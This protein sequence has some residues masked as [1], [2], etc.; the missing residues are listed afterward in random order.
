MDLSES[1]WRNWSIHQV[2]SENITGV[3]GLFGSEPLTESIQQ[4]ALL[5]LLLQ[6]VQSIF[7][8]RR[9]HSEASVYLKDV[10]SFKVSI[11]LDEGCLE[12]YVLKAPQQDRG[13]KL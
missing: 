8:H 7:I 13:W 11:S 9:K 2:H 1:Y 3:G 4:V 6:Q 12:H 5:F 10:S